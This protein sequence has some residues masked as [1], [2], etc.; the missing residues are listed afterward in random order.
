MSMTLKDLRAKREE[1]VEAAKPL[2]ERGE[3]ELT[4]E[5]VKKLSEYASEMREVDSQLD[6]M[7]KSEEDRKYL[8]DARSSKDDARMRAGRPIYGGSRQ[9][10]AGDD[11]ALN[12]VLSPGE[13][14]TRSAQYD[15]WLKRYP[16]GGPPNNV[17]AQSDVVSV[18]GGQY[19]TMLNMRS[20]TEKWRGGIIDPIKARTLITSADAS[21]GLWVRPE[22][23][24]LL[25]PGLPGRPLTIRQ[26]VTVLPTRSDAIEYIRENSRI[27]AAAPVTEAVQL[28]HT[29]DVTATKPEGGLTFATVTDVV[30]QIALWVPA[31]KRI[32]SDAPQLQE[33]INSY[34]TDDIAIELEDQM[35]SGT[36]GAGFTGLF[37]TA[38]TQTL[39]PPAGGLTELDLV[40][41]AKR[42]IRTNARTNA[43]AILAN[44]EDVE[45]WDTIKDTASGGYLVRPDGAVT[46]A[47]NG[48]SSLWGIPVVESEACPVGFALVG[49]FRR[50]VLFD[51]EDVQISVGTADQDFIR[52]IVRVLAEM[53][54]GFGVLRPAAF[55]E[56]DLVA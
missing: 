29:G 24:G 21:A 17:Q 12:S 10:T 13:V 26:L 11:E 43:T 47:G 37:N 25:E 15:E 35:V 6:E 36:G 45:R 28:A 33:Y 55:V 20:A 32:L 3:D 41:R 46:G 44:P 9:D 53:R 1:L 48:V 5:D 52:N 19:R 27:S 18:Q 38:G 14:Y 50:A 54:A 2:A 40:R 34:L 42:L 23:R 51:R 8:L 7:E 49:D 30:K 56:V 16:T 4:P 39:G 22:Y 31:T